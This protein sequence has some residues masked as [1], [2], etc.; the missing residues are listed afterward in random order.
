[1]GYIKV[2]LLSNYMLPDPPRVC[3][4]LLRLEF[5]FLWKDKISGRAKRSVRSQALPLLLSSVRG[6]TLG[7]TSLQIISSARIIVRCA[8]QVIIIVNID[9]AH[10]DILETLNDSGSA[11]HTVRLWSFAGRYISTLGTFREW[12]PI[13]PAVY[14][15]KYFEDYKLPAD[16]KEF[17]SST[18]LKVKW[19]RCEKMYT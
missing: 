5:P 14:V 13:L 2:W 15:E 6:H 16:V 10:F 4:P 8:H 19:K 12:A 17:A 9:A 1:M 3:M 18:T 7:V 11:D